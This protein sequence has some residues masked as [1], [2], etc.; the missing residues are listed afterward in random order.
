MNNYHRKRSRNSKNLVDNNNSILNEAQIKSKVDIGIQVAIDNDHDL[1]VQIDALKNSLANIVT[2]HAEQLQAIQIKNCKI[3][4][5][6][7]EYES[8]KN[9]IAN[10]NIKLKDL[11]SYQNQLCTNLLSV[12]EY[13]DN[14]NSELRTQPDP[15]IEQQRFYAYLRKKQF[16][17]PEKINNT[18]TNLD[19]DVNL[20]EEIKLFSILAQERRQ[21]FIRNILLQQTGTDIWHPILVTKQEADALKNEN[22]IR[23]EELIAIINSILISIPESQHP[24]YTNLKNM[25]KATLLT[26]L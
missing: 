14:E 8:L 10:I 24:K 2:D 26:I 22:A 11:N 17:N 1:L 23:K 25:T 9:Q 5:L 13:E 16:L 3:I 15:Y 21:K 18:I 19:G 12:I 6:E 7:H 20:S 4:E